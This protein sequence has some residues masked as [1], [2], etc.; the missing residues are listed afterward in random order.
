MDIEKN[1]TSILQQAETV[2]NNTASYVLDRPDIS[3]RVNQVKRLRDCVEACV[4]ECF[5]YQD[6]L[7]QKC[8]KILVMNV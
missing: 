7:S 3:K 1:L 2:C 8:G 4:V 6:H 5:K